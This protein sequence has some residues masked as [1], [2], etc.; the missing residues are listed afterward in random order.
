MKVQDYL[1]SIADKAGLCL[2]WSETP[3]TAFLAIG[4]YIKG[5]S[6]GNINGQFLSLFVKKNFL[7][8]DP[9]HDVEIIYGL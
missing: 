5:C 1:I 3:K 8:C 6:V 2:T 4:I 7:A 9:R